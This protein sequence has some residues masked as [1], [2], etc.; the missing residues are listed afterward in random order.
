MSKPQLLTFIRNLP[1]FDGRKYAMFHCKCGLVKRIRTYAVA[2]GSTRSC[3]CLPTRKPTHGHA[4][5]GAKSPEYRSWHNM[6]Q[7]CGNPNNTWYI[8]YGGRGIRV[9]KRWSTFSRFLVDM[10]LKPSLRHTL[11]RID[12]EGRYSPTNCR[13]ATRKEQIAN[14]R[15][16]KRQS[17]LSATHKENIR[18]GLLRYN[19][20]N[21]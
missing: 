10:G 12:N 21:R 19:R 18:Q 14:R 3:G 6:K 15:P 13:W 1:S 2:S 17:H 5:R 11:E 9:C 7:R 4:F 16:V 20:A 8:N